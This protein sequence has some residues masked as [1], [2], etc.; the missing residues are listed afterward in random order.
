MRTLFSSMAISADGFH[1]AVDKGLSWQTFGQE[2]ADHSVE[3]LDEIDTLVL[4][5][6]TFEELAAYWRSDLGTDFD[7]RIADRM[8]S[9]AKIVVSTRPDPVDWPGSSVRLASVE[10]LAD[11]KRAA[12]K[13]IAVFGSS[14]LT[15]A[16]LRAGLV[17]ELRLMV[18]P[19][20]LGDGLRVFPTAGTVPMTLTRVRP[21][22][23]GNVLLY[24]RPGT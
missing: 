15:G 24:Y 21:F 1:A 10:E 16:L 18:N 13:D 5:R 3:Q 11:V 23:A 7:R 6:T 8:N 2:F 14:T 17:D 20:L 22:A 12:G 4:G 9:V 19:I